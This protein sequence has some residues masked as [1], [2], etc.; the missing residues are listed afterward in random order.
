MAYSLLQQCY[1]LLQQRQ[2]I[3]TTEGRGNKR[4]ILGAGNKGKILGARQ[5]F[6]LLFTLP[7]S[8]TQTLTDACSAHAISKRCV[9][10]DLVHRQGEEE[11]ARD[12]RHHEDE[13]EGKRARKSSKESQQSKAYHEAVKEDRG[14]GRRRRVQDFWMARLEAR[15]HAKAHRSGDAVEQHHVPEHHRLPLALIRAHMTH[16][17][18]A[19]HIPP[20]PSRSV[21]LT[22]PQSSAPRTLTRTQDSLRALMPRHAQRDRHVASCATQQRHKGDQKKHLAG[23]RH[24]NNQPKRNTIRTSRRCWLR[25]G[26]RVDTRCRCACSCVTLAAGVHRACVPD[27]VNDPNIIVAHHLP[28]RPGAQV[29]SP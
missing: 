15:R 19:H 9:L 28:G 22:L 6:F 23:G 12:L 11:E 29:K 5:S 8:G 18:K 16:P 7:S 26:M 17:H 21:S 13:E 14:G 2:A 3:T 25:L 27:R 1:S 4:K 10:P 24:N 20:R